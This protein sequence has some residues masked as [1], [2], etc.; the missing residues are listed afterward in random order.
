VAGC[1]ALIGQSPYTYLQ[2]GEP[3]YMGKRIAKE[4]KDGAKS[5]RLAELLS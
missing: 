3:M 5:G 4:I 2:Y 1:N